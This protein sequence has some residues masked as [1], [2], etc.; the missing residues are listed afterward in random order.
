MVPAS[1]TCASGVEPQS[2]PASP[3]LLLPLL[4]PLEPP[5]EP[6]LLPPLELPLLEPL[7]LPLAL[8]SLPGVTGLLLLLLQ[9][10]AD[11]PPTATVSAVPKTKVRVRMFIAST[12]FA[13]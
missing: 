9:A 13:Y 6:P 5:L 4:E 12:P 8:P 11:T 10:T 7:L 1:A 3:P 2:T